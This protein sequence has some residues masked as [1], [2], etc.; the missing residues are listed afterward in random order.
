MNWKVGAPR[1]ASFPPGAEVIG[2]AEDCPTGRCR[3]RAGSIAG[4]ACQIV[5]HDGAFC[6]RSLMPGV[7][8]NLA[9]VATDAGLVRLRSG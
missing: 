1:N 8:I 6:L 2:H 7:M 3:N 5:L 4:R 9:P